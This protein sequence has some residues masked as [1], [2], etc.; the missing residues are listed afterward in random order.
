MTAV[1]LFVGV[2]VALG[3]SRA[4]AG[5]CETLAR[6]ARGGGLTLAWV[7]PA[8]Y[9]VTVAFLGGARP[10]VVPAVRAALA[11]V[12]RAARPFRFRCERLGA[13]ASPERATVVWAGIDDASGDLA[14]LAHEAGAAMA[15]LGFATDPRPYRPH[16]TLAR[17][18]APEPVSEVLLPLSEQV[19]GESRCD[20]LTLYE[21]S[22]VANG[23]EYG[24]IAR[25]AL[26]TPKSVA[27]RQ[28]DTVQT[29]PFDASHGSDDGWDRTS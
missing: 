8:R 26:G 27:E 1:R 6:R 25:E 14:R 18:K 23:Y 17:L 15:D 16:V 7:P 9:H 5:A 12:A 3:V 11:E 20:A 29:A 2:P 28:T 13:F 24:V 19:F 21:S 10:E 4:L 22:L